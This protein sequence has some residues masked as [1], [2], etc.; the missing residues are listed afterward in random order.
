M[1]IFSCLYRSNVADICILFVFV[2]RDISQCIL[3]FF[4]EWMLEYLKQIENYFSWKSKNLSNWKVQW[5]VNNFD[6]LHL[7]EHPFLQAVGTSIIRK[8]GI[9]QELSNHIKLW[10][11]IFFFLLRLLNL[12]SLVNSKKH[13]FPF[14]C[15]H[16]Y[17]LK[18][19]DY[20][21]CRSGSNS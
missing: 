2:H 16:R 9:V 17:L 3:A 7:I 13:C 12:E 14:G 6:F 21:Q 1:K 15:I 19:I 5:T 20:L 18:Y 8:P 11:R 10:G 4:N